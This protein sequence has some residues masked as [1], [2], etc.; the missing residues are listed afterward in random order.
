MNKSH[1]IAMSISAAFATLIGCNL[2]TGSASISNAQVTQGNCGALNKTAPTCTVTLSYNTGGESSI[3][4][5]VIATP[6][7]PTGQFNPAFGS[8]VLTSGPQTCPVVVTYARPPNGPVP[9]T[10]VFTLGTGESA[11]K[12]TGIQFVGQ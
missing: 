6:A 1:L 9:Q 10:L 12:S 11:A 7:Q 2:G 4:F 8:C 3:T 5:G